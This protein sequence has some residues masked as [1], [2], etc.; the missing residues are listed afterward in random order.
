MSEI[1]IILLLLAPVLLV[2]F[3]LNNSRKKQK[4]KKQEKLSA[5]LHSITDQAGMKH[6]FEQQLIHQMVIIDESSRKIIVVNQREH[7]LSHE[8]YSLDFIKTVKVVNVKQTIPGEQNKKGE[9]ITTEIG[10][11][12]VFEKP[13]KEV[14]LVFY[15]H[16]EHTIFQMAELEKA[17]SQMQERITKARIQ[18]LVNT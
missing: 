6:S 18:Q 5:Y 13:D 16:T 1:V 15:D 7:H 9:V 2:V 12:I 4:K 10:V 11:E 14:F 8:Q 17:A 3:I